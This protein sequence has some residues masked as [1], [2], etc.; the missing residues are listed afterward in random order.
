MASRG[1]GTERLGSS[2]VQPQ[3]LSRMA[4]YRGVEWTQALARVRLVGCELLVVDTGGHDVKVLMS[5]M[6]AKIETMR[7]CKNISHLAKDPAW[8]S[9]TQQQEE[10]EG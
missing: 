2:E 7:H 4:A 10:G 6:L 1:K 3:A 5:V 8:K 9:S